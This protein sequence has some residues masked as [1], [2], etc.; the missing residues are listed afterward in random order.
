M[1][2]YRRAM[3]NVERGFEKLLTN[4]VSDM[5]KTLHCTISAV[6]HVLYLNGLFSEPSNYLQKCG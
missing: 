1:D 6:E 2:D 5:E 4:V 3:H